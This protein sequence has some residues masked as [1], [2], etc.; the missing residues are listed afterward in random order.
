MIL[1]IIEQAFRSY[2]LPPL[3]AAPAKTAPP[4]FWHCASRSAW[5]SGGSCCRSTRWPRTAHSTAGRSRG[6]ASSLLPS[7]LAAGW[8]DW[9]GCFCSLAPFE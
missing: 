8:L 6:R 7:L 4:P 3:A 9:R 5:Q 2:H 1:I